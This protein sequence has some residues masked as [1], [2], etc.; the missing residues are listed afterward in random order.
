[1]PTV[2]IQCIG[3]GKDYNRDMHRPTIEPIRVR[4]GETD[5]MGHANSAAYVHWFEQARGAHC[6]ARGF[7]Y[8]EL[9]AEGFLLPVIEIAIQYRG[10]VLY[11]DQIEVEIILSELK[12]VSLRFDYVVRRAGQTQI[13]TTGMTRHAVLSA[14]NHRPAAMPTPFL[15]R[16]R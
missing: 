9:E 16:I 14:K 11:D 4:Y 10:E 3:D 13:L 12:R 15:E 8:R 6:R 1:M 2:P 5:Q 7:S